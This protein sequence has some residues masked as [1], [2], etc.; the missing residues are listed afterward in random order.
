MKYLKLFESKKRNWEIESIWIDYDSPETSIGFFE[1]RMVDIPNDEM[2]KIKKRLENKGLILKKSNK[3]WSVQNKES[4]P[5]FIG[6]V[7]SVFFKIDDEYFIL[8]DNAANCQEVDDGGGI[9]EEY[10]KCDQLY[11]FL[12]LL[13]TYD[14]STY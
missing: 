13:D 1:K 12:E 6:D 5:A 3:Y 2:L 10:Y 14:F 11:G 8:I 9:E 7:D 4:D